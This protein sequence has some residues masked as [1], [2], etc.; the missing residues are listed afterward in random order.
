MDGDLQA[1]VDSGKISTKVAAALE[2]LTPDTYCLHKSWGF[3]RVAS[4]NLLLN[5]ILIDFEGKKQHPMQLQYAAES[6]Q[7]L[8]DSHILVRKVTELARLQTLASEEP[9]ALVELVLESFGGKVT[10][11]QLEKALAPEIF[12]SA[13]FK[14]WW[15]ATKKELRKEG[16]FALPAKKAD[17]L[18]LR[19]RSLS[20]ADE[21]LQTFKG[22]R[23]LKEQI[24]ALDQLTKNSDSL[25]GYESELSSVIEQVEDIASRNVRLNAAQAIELVIARD[26]LLHRFPT[27]PA[28]KVPLANLL[29]ENESRLSEIIAQIPAAKQR[30]VL[31]DYE[32]AF[33]ENW[34][35]RLIQLL[36]TAGY[37]VVGEI[38]KILVEHGKT[39]DLRQSLVRM[40]R[41]HSVSSEVLYWLA[42]ERGASHFADLLEPE[43][44]SA[45]LSALERDQF[46]E[47][48]R[49]S[50]L[51][52]LLMDDKEL[53]SD[54]MA[55]APSSQA[56]DLM[57]R[58]MLSP[59]FEDLNKRSLMGRMIKLHPELE[60][61]ITGESEE[62]GQAL[63]VSW[64]SL[65]KRKEE[66]DDLVTKKIPENTKEISVARS[67]GDLRENFE[68]KAAKEMQTVLMRRKAELEQMLDR[69]RGSNFENVDTNQVS[70]GT[71]VTVRDSTNSDE[72]TYHILGAWDSE[73]EKHVVS[74]LTAIGQALL[75]KRVSDLVELPT[76][77][78][79]RQVEVLEIAPHQAELETAE[80][81]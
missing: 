65:Q 10:V 79:T 26:E 29:K 61:M 25:A 33:P 21:L 5:Q 66:Y 53:V 39:D 30:R 45:M 67:Y 68:Y 32:V 70:I 55:T 51:H 71:A 52:D 77:S 20:F 63:I 4:W 8:A 58:V 60:S 76:E 12:P 56:R 47:S 78:G 19:D 16:R 6:L 59:A 22:A 1:L 27:L 50:R 38:A 31:N 14:K 49:S 42:R 62:K 37:R 11:D 64:A 75:G 9:T 46:G 43:L 80:A 17:F 54:L 2:K 73:P 57:R 35:L 15:D 3:G 36:L 74:Y 81:G 44:M 40:I 18:V 7:P 28:A 48:K 23:Q 24:A 72:I 69:A 41:E 34:D 13:N